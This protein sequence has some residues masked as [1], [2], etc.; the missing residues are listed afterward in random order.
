[1]KCKRSV[2]VAGKNNIAVTVVE[3]IRGNYPEV[4][5]QAVVNSTD[6]GVD[7]FQRSFKKYCQ[8]NGINIIDL[9][10]TYKIDDLV[11][12]S[13]EFDK[14]IKPSLF[15]SEYL[16]NIHFSKLPAYKGMYTSAWP[17]INGEGETGV[18]LHKI[19]SGIDT[20]DIIAQSVFEISEDETAA[21][22]Y[23]KYISFGTD[24]VISKL[25]TLFDNDI[26]YI[27]QQAKGASYYS[28][29]TIDYGNVV[30]DLNKT[31]I[32]IKN[33]IN[34]FTFRAYQLPIVFGY[35]VCGCEILDA[36]STPKA[37]TVLEDT[38]TYIILST[39]D[40]DIKVY[41][42]TFSLL[43]KSCAKND[44]ELVR[45][46]LNKFNVNEK[47]D[48]GWSPIIVAAYNGQLNVI[49][50]LLEYGAN[51][52]DINHNGTT[53]FMYAKDYA[54]EHN[55]VEYLKELKYL[56]ADLSLSDYRG[57]TVFDYLEDQKNEYW[58]SVLSSL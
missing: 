39:V 43:M 18:T 11:F 53:V 25:D 33:A 26:V 9:S 35:H 12:L 1:M 17:I 46:Y 21:S 2:V 10:E 7:G 5:I 37:G 47:N 52:N 20:G 19:D 55:S 22:L 56:G 41:K 34:A 42:D 29:K 32:E 36:N 38:N 49:R 50:L 15:K 30:I 44:L 24:L 14:I 54:I 31:A 45:T 6:K 51:I 48:K 23:Q 16:Y 27:R 57:M 58:L 13:L 40:F 28:K 4:S 8:L 3:Y